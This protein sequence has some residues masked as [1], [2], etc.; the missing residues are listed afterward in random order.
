MTE[1][2][3]TDDEL[4]GIDLF[5]GDK[6]DGGAKLC[7]SRI[8]MTRKSHICVFSD[9]HEIPIGSRARAEKALIDDKWRSFYVCCDCLKQW[10]VE[11][12]A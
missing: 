9:R 8:V 6:D 1:F 12:D 3:F 7:A 2:Q 4:L 11:V 10:L 5:G